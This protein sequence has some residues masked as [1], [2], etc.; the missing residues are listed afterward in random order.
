MRHSIR[1]FRKCP[2]K[3]AS[4][5][6]AL[7]LAALAPSAHSE[8]LRIGVGLGVAGD[9][10]STNAG[11]FGMSVSSGHGRKWEGAVIRF[12]GRSS[13]H[14]SH[15]SRWVLTGARRFQ[16]GRMFFVLGA[17]L[18]E[19]DDDVLSGHLQWLTG[20]GVATHDVDI[21][22][23]HLSNAGLVGRNRGETWLF[24]TRYL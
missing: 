7:V 16:R 1:T 15:G 3:E 4:L 6:L 5:C 18:N 22:I 2:G 17:G 9:I 23:R 13:I 11:T 8:V 14:S 12:G 10:D 19:R 21:S 20:V 24:V